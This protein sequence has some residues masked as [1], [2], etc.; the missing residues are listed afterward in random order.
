MTLCFNGQTG[1]PVPAQ[2]KAKVDP[3]DK[4]TLKYIMDRVRRKLRAYV[5]MQ[6]IFVS[7]RYMFS[8]IY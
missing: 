5:I 6:E 7:N 1:E 3:R 2:L 8:L 4:T